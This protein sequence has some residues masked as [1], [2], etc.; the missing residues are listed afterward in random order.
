LQIAV[1][2]G[3]QTVREFIHGRECLVT[4]LGDTVMSKF[5]ASVASFV[6]NEKAS[7]IAT[8]AAAAFAGASVNRKGYL[9]TILA[10]YLVDVKGFCASA[11]QVAWNV[12]R[13][14]SLTCLWGTQAMRDAGFSGVCPSAE[15]A[16]GKDSP[17]N[18]KK[19]WNTAKV[20]LSDFRNK[21]EAEGYEM[22]YRRESA[23]VKRGAQAPKGP[24]SG[25]DA[26]E[27]EDAPK[28]KKSEAQSLGQ[29][30]ANA[31]TPEQ[32]ATFEALAEKLIPATKHDAFA[33]MVALI[34]AGTSFRVEIREE[35]STP[36]AS[37]KKPAA[38]K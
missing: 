18:I 11:D 28:A 16:P 35:S 25:E 6:S 37:G 5:N 34:K 2:T 31:S 9:Q 36:K 12:L 17:D 32:W 15:N 10:T 13:D 19:L 29:V 33:Q 26:D 3:T 23:G 21:L 38:K 22:L 8:R 14:Y 7:V 24:Q 20:A 30:I 4:F 27:S 1:D